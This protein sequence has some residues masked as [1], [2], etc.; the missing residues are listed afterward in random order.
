MT[1][2]AMLFVL[3]AIVLLAL[4]A[5]A[6]EPT[7]LSSTDAPKAPPTLRQ[8]LDETAGRIVELWLTNGSG[9]KRKMSCN[10]QCTQ[11]CEE[12]R[13]EC[14]LYFPQWQCNQ[15][16]ELCICENQCCTNPC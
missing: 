10:F 13:R 4:P 15:E 9:E 8:G 3:L 6:S 7:L 14:L 12:L 5:A 2:T 11:W 1:R 16:W